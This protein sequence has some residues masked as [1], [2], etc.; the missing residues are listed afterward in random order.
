MR[1]LIKVEF[2]SRRI[3]TLTTAQLDLLQEWGALVFESRRFVELRK[4]TFWTQFLSNESF[5]MGVFYTLNVFC[6]QA[7]LL[8]YRYMLC[9][10]RPITFACFWPVGRSSVQA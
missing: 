6:I 5:G 7:R 1:N 4:Q 10:S 8:R 2:T 3:S 9:L